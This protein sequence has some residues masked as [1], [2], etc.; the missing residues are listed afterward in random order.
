MASPYVH[1]KALTK[2]SGGVS[3]NNFNARQ[4]YTCRSLQWTKKTLNSPFKGLKNPFFVPR[5]D[6]QG[7]RQKKSPKVWKIKIF[8]FPL[9]ER[10]TTPVLLITGAYQGV[11]GLSAMRGGGGEKDHNIQCDGTVNWQKRY[12]GWFRNVR[13]FKTSTRNEKIELYF[14]RYKIKCFPVPFLKILI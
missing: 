11:Y 9:M 13:I 8:W 2:L 1:S 12:I 3:P 7:A 4:V 10:V 5:C 14:W 6:S